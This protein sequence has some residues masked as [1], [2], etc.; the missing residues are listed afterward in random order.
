MKKL[1]I[2]LTDLQY[3]TG[4]GIKQAE[5]FAEVTV[6]TRPDTIYNTPMGDYIGETITDVEIIDTWLFVYNND[7]EVIK[8]VQDCEDFNEEIKREAIKQFK[9]GN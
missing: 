2:E 4:Y 8:E 6:H 3:D 5:M 7:Y 9:K 1:S